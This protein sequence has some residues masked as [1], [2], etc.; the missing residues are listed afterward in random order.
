MLS[1]RW[2]KNAYIF[3]VSFECFDCF[4]NKLSIILNYISRSFIAIGETVGRAFIGEA[5]C[6]DSI[7][8]REAIV[9]GFYD[10][11]GGFE[12]VRQIGGRVAFPDIIFMCLSTLFDRKAVALLVTYLN[13]VLSVSL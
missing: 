10:K 7:L 11:H 3:P 8:D 4:E 13:Q 9:G 2:R 12:V 1:T 6:I 5:V